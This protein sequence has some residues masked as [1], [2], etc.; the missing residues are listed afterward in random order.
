[1]HQRLQDGLLQRF[2]MLWAWRD[3]SSASSGSSS[4][5]KSRIVV[6]L[7]AMAA[8]GINCMSENQVEQLNALSHLAMSSKLATSQPCSTI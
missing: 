2:L 6:I 4:S 3:S 7:V 8:T 1:M 5:G